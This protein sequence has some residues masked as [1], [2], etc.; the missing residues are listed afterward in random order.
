MYC[1]AGVLLVDGIDYGGLFGQLSR[2]PVALFSDVSSTLK[3]TS[4]ALIAL[5][6]SGV[7]V[8]TVFMANLFGHYC[9]VSAEAILTALVDAPGRGIAGKIGAGRPSG[10][11]RLADCTSRL[12]GLERPAGSAV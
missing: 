3:Q 12:C 1:N 11:D 10:M 7:T 4:G 8:G 9:L 5:G 2:S 6:D